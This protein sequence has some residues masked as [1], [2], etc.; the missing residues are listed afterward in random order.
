MTQPEELNEPRPRMIAIMAVHASLRH[1]S[2]RGWLNVAITVP[3]D[4]PSDPTSVGKRSAR[5]A[6]R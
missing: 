5:H 3:R 6:E 2:F 4:E 1:Q